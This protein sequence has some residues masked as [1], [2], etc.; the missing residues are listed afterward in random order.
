MHSTWRVAVLSDCCIAHLCLQTQQQ[1]SALGGW[2][3]T[4]IWSQ[5]KG[6]TF[7][8]NSCIWMDTTLSPNL[9]NYTQPAAAAR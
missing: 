6:K 5:H 2:K 8:I 3:A 7:E 9:N 4:L 1:N